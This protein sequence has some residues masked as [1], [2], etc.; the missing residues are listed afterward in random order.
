VARFA[1]NDTVLTGLP[2]KPDGDCRPVLTVAKFS[3]VKAG[4]L[5]RGAAQGVGKRDVGGL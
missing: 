2:L 5:K 1:K 4:G 3:P